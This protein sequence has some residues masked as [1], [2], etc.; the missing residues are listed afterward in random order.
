MAALAAS[1]ASWLLD[2]AI[3]PWCGTA[4]RVVASLVV[5]TFGFTAARRFFAELRS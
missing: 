1:V 5:G 4:V 2:A 3:S